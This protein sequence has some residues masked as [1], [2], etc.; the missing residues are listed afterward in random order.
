[1]GVSGQLHL[2]MHGVLPLPLLPNSKLTSSRVNFD[3]TDLKSSVIFHIRGQFN[4]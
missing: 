1:M 3:V 4:K 2:R